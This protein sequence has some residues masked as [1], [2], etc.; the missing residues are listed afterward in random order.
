MA[1]NVREKVYMYIYIS[2]VRVPRERISCIVIENGAE[3]GTQSDPNGAK[4]I[5]K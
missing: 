2:L 5:A 4:R 3:K 1:H